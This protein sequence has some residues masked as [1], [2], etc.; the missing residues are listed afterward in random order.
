MS[1]GLTPYFRLQPNLKQLC[2]DP[3]SSR[4]ETR[5]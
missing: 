4:E 5:S 3:S 1:T 2:A